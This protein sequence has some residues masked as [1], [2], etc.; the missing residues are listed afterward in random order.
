MSGKAITSS[1][2]RSIA[3]RSERQLLQIE[4]A[5]GGVYSYSGVP[6][7][8]HTALLNAESPGR[9][10]NQMIRNCFPSAKGDSNLKS[11]WH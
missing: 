10:F 8:V 1:C 11:I 6:D 3:Y 4:F 2:L 5:D 9:F 7:T